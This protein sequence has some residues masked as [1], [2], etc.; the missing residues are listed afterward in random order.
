MEGI[1]DILSHMAGTELFTHQLPSV[2]RQAE[3]VLKAAHPFLNEIV[4]PTI[5]TAEECEVFVN[6]IV[7]KY[8]EFFAVAPLE[9]ADIPTFAEAVA[10]AKSNRDG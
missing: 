7:E 8:G 2:G 4:V 5:T 10:L 9:T 6:E 3:P 1:Y